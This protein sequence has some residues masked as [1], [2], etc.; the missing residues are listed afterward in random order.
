MKKIL[1][2]R[3]RTSR[4]QLIRL[5]IQTQKRK[6]AQKLRPRKT[7]A[8]STAAFGNL[9]NLLNEMLPPS[10]WSSAYHLKKEKF[11][12][13]HN[14]GEENKQPFTTE[15]SQEL[16]NEM[17]KQY[18]ESESLREKIITPLMSR[19]KVIW[20]KKLDK[21]KLKEKLQVRAGKAVQ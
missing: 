10:V 9:D 15:D 6:I 20:T 4:C 5:L 18:K 7:D 1:P 8:V 16:W 12:K 21:E 14:H 2:Q 17:F 11:K 19:T 3:R 13:T